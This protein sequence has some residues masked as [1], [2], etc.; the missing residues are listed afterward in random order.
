M[1]ASDNVLGIF[2]TGESFDLREVVRRPIA[3]NDLG[4]SVW[5]F[6]VAVA[7]LFRQPNRQGLVLLPP[8]V[9]LLTPSAKAF[10]RDLQQLFIGPLPAL[11]CES[12]SGCS[13]VMFC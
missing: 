8:V 4:C 13:A 9:T 6:P 5:A 11:F 10:R 12:R 1:L 2:P 3:S 7:Y